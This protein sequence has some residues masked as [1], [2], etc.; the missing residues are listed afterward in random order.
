VVAEVKTTEVYAIK[1]STLL[2][3]I[4]DL[5]SEKTIPAESEVLGLYVVGRPDRELNQLQ[6]AIVAEKK[7]DR[8]RT[9]SA[10]S[11]L[12]LAELMKEYDIT[13][14]DILGLIRPT[15][16]SIDP[17]IELIAKLVA[18]EKT[19]STTPSNNSKP[20]SIDPTAAKA[21]LE[22]SAEASEAAFWLTPVKS[23][24]EQT[25]EECIQQLVGKHHIYAFGQNTPGRKRIKP[26]DRI[27]FYSNGT[28]VVAHATVASPPENKPHKAVRQ[29]ANYPWVFRLADATL[30]L[31]E[32][33]VIDP[34]T[35]SN[36]DAFRGKDPNKGWAWF[37]QGTGRV[38][39]HD[40]SVLTRTSRTD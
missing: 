1:T 39:G 7:S 15:A 36:L 25:A 14:D 21:S 10:E 29:S 11:L 24:P 6:A 19:A 38:T 35:R 13:H 40:F 2:N 37:V 33:V 31:K 23:I 28:G 4:N 26:G 17:L 32:P 27:A 12:S 22:I 5:I 34:A 16:P 18:E 20:D 9:A 30:Y 8:L 3:Y